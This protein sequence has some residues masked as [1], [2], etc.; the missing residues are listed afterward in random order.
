MPVVRIPDPIYKRLQAIAVPFEDTPVTVI[1][2]LLNEYELHHKSQ[3]VSNIDIENFSQTANYSEIDNYKILDPDTPSNLTYSKVLRALVDHQ[4]IH[5]PNWNR[6]IAKAHEIAI[7]KGISVEDLLELTPFH[8]VPGEKNEDGFRYLP[9]I[10]ISVQGVG[11]NVAWCKTLYLMKKLKLPIEIYFKWGNEEG[12]AY[13]G[14]K[15]K[16]CWSPK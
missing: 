15:G 11:A 16:L 1:E 3:Q 10:N 6:I 9:E 4:E 8:V 7:N 13:P 14:E 12:A 2:K 5:N